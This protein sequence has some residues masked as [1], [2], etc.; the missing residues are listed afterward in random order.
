MYTVHYHTSH[1]IKIIHYL[2]SSHKINYLLITKYKN[3]HKY[4]MKNVFI[5]QKNILV[6]EN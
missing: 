2:L 1:L 5:V 6:G 4:L 3:R